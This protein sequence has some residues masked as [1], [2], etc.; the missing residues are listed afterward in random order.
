MK[1]NRYRIGIR[2]PDWNRGYGNRL[3]G[4]IRDFIQSGNPL[5]LE[6]DQPS[7]D[8]FE[9]V[10]I[11]EDWKGD[12]LLVYRYSSDEARAWRR[13]RIPVV[14][15]SAEEPERGPRF[16]RVTLD[17]E[18]A[19][20]LAAEH[21]E[22]LG[23]R[24]FAFWH[25]PGRQYS[26]ERLAG[27]RDRIAE[28][29]HECTILEVPASLTPVRARSRL[30]AKLGI[31][32]VARLA[33]PAALFAK[34]DLAGVSVIRAL[35]QAGLRCP[36]DVAVLGVSDDIVRCHL[37]SPGMS[38]LR[39]PGR[40]L[41]FAAAELLYR[42]ME[43]ERVDSGYRK[44][45]PSPGIVQRESTE[46]VEFPDPAVTR[47]LRLIRREAPSGKLAVS[48]VCQEAGISREL[49]RQRFQAILGRSVKQE[50]D[51]VRSEHVAEVLRQ[52][53][54]TLEQIATGCGFNGGDELCRFFRRIKGVTPHQ[55]RKK[56]I[57]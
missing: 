32:G 37:V 16:P 38:S 33:P 14:N 57:R 36:E 49:M 54:S 41:G 22:S 23:V 28:A 55:W 5:E 53:E 25:D 46:H 21:L 10:R 24:Q 12:G 6:F 9:P 27:F 44:R 43:G 34:D 30:V 39:F 56:Q 15:L 47:A 4:G 13:R 51:R 2:L 17:N 45:I 18:R 31:E 11:G 8:Y 52:T 50:I 29:N 35:K 48:M 42:M 40:R 20:S 3:F 7:A 26:R 1:P 19:G